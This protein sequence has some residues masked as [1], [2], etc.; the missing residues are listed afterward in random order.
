MLPLRH[1]AH[2]RLQQWS[3]SDIIDSGSAEEKQTIFVCIVEIEQT[4]GFTVSRERP[5]IA[6][7]DVASSTSW[8]SSRFAEELEKAGSTK[9][10]RTNQPSR[11]TGS[12]PSRIHIR[13]SCAT[14]GQNHEEGIFFIEPEA[15]FNISFG[16]AY[17]IERFSSKRY[18]LS[19][20]TRRKGKRTEQE[21]HV[22]DRAVEAFQRGIEEGILFPLERMPQLPGGLAPLMTISDLEA[23]LDHTYESYSFTEQALSTVSNDQDNFSYLPS[24]YGDTFSSVNLASLKESEIDN[25]R[26]YAAA[27]TNMSVSGGSRRTHSLSDTFQKEPAGTSPAYSLEGWA[28][29]SL[30]EEPQPW[31][32]HMFRSE[33]SPFSFKRCRELTPKR[34]AKLAATRAAAEKETSDYWQWDEEAQSYK[35]YDEGCSEPVWYN[36]PSEHTRIAHNNSS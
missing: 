27:S 17:D 26:S 7:C 14:L 10:S 20:Y 15:Q 16:C 11:R 35:H 1:D 23:E 18:Q 4:A 31:V 8:I 33:K 9:L 12:K 25:E 13:W 28:T 22:S 24:S 2:T 21:L 6:L 32:P 19:H 34:Q 3:K 29:Q 30:C 36:P 5:V